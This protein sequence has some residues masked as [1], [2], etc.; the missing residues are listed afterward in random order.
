M[1]TLWSTNPDDYPG[2]PWY[3]WATNSEGEVVGDTI[4]FFEDTTSLG[5]QINYFNTAEYF[6]HYEYDIMTDQDGGL[7]FTAMSWPYLCEDIEGGCAD[8]IF[9]G[10][11][12]VTS[13]DS[14]A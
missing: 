6:V 13:S 3:P 12:E 9:D 7:H 1:L 14:I 10:D 8:Y 4:Q 11:L 5:E 2:K